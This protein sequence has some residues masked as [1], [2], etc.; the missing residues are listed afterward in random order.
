MVSVSDAREVYRVLLRAHRAEL[1]GSDNGP[2]WLEGASCS[3]DVK[4]LAMIA[5]SASV[6]GMTAEGWRAMLMSEGGPEALPL[7]D[8]AEACMRGSGLWPWNQA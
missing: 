7:L 8:T 5:S 4:E 2:E 6:S 3:P 1:D